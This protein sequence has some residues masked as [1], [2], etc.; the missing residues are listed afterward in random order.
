MKKIIILILIV[1]ILMLN[2]CSNTESDLYGVE[3]TSNLEGKVFKDSVTVVQTDKYLTNKYD[4]PIATKVVLGKVELEADLISVNN[5]EY[6]SNQNVFLSKDKNIEFRKSTDYGSFTIQSKNNTVLVSFDEDSLTEEKLKCYVLDYISN[7][8]D[9]DRL[10]DYEYNCS[11]SVVVAKQ[12]ASWKET[13]DTFYLP[14]DDT[15]I[16]TDYK[17]EF[18]K[19]SQG[20]Q[21]ADSVVVICNNA[22][23]IKGIY[24]YEYNVNWENSSFDKEK[25]NDSVEDFL[26]NYISSEYRLL[27][28][29]VESQRLV[30]LDNQI[31][32]SLSISVTLQ[33]G[34]DEIVILCPCLVSET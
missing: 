3:L 27:D 24:N 16:V 5:Y 31:K 14:Q 28:Y 33:S 26:K 17:M 9:I 23:D 29:S 7:Y 1:L 11:T 18:R 4:S 2:S 8:I 32:L 34:K 10:S 12:N 21:T 22:G 19:Y 20:F 25:V 30:Y 13:K 6:K 15:E